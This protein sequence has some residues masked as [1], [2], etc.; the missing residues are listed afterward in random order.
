MTDENRCSGNCPQNRIEISFQAAY[1]EKAFLIS[2]SDQ[3]I[4]SNPSYFVF[5]S[6]DVKQLEQETAGCAKYEISKSFKLSSNFSL[7]L[8]LNKLVRVSGEIIFTS[9]DN[10][11]ALTPKKS[12]ANLEYQYTFSECTRRK[13]L[14]I[15]ALPINLQNLFFFVP[16][17]IFDPSLTCTHA[18]SGNAK[19]VDQCKS[20]NGTFDLNFAGFHYE[21]VISLRMSDYLRIYM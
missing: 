8:S 5:S 15:F 19:I 6:Q 10:S 3:I 1:F 16:V 12:T 20:I 18:Q 9:R 7:H 2:P 13:E 4:I 14:Q 21:E 17:Q 11:T